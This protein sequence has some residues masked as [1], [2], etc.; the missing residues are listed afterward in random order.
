MKEWLQVNQVG[1]TFSQ[2]NSFN[3]THYL[4]VL[5]KGK[6]IHCIMEEW[7]QGNQVGH[8]LDKNKP[9]QYNKVHEVAL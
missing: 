5:S 8:T 6:H 3:A 2:G 9:F 4:V 1:H 7:L